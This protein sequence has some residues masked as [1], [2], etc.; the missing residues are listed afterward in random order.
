ME[1]QVNIPG[2]GET[3]LVGHR[4]QHLLHWKGA[5]ALGRQL[6]G[7]LTGAKIVPFQPHE[8][9]L[10]ILGRVPVFHPHQLGPGHR[11]LCLGPYLL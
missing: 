11:L 8:V 7:W 5:M 3:Q 10:V 4:R 6:G 2:Q 9:P 1:H